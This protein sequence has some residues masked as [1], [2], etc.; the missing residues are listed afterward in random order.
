MRKAMFFATLLL[1]FSMN[2]PAQTRAQ[3][4]GKKVVVYGKVSED[5]KILVG[6]HHTWSVNNPSALAGREGR[7]VRV[8]CRLYADTSKIEVLSVKPGDAQMQYATRYD[9][10][11]FHS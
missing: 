1:V 5:G 6:D 7:I 9:D 11:A 8:E 2:A 10:P 4:T 3:D